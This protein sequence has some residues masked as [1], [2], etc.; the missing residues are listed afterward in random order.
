M[1]NILKKIFNSSRKYLKKAKIL[2]DQI[3]KLDE[4]MTKLKDEDFKKET[5]RLKNIFCQKKNLDELLVEAYALAREASYRITGMKPYYVQLLGAII[6]HQG[7]VAEMK[8]GEGKTLT[9][10]MPSYLNSLSGQSVHIVTVNE[11]LASR[12]AEGIIS[13]VFNFLGLSVGLNTK[14]K[15]NIEK[16]QAY[17]C[18]ILYSTNS[19]LSFDYLRDNMQIDCKNL[20]MQ[21]DYGYAIVD[22]VDSIL[23]D[24]ARTPL[25]ISNQNRQTEFIYREAD[26]FVRTLKNNH[27]II[28]L[29]TKTIEL[30][31][32]GINKAE[33]FFQINNLY[34]V[35]H[36]PL[37]HRIKN[38]LK[39]FFLMH[40]NKDYL[41][42]KDQ[43]LII[44]EFTGRILKGRQF[45][46]G[47][48]QALEAKERVTIKP[49]TTIS[50][51]ITYQNFFRLY[52]KISGMTGTAKTEEDEFRNIYNMEVI[53]IPTNKPMIRIDD[54][55]F[56]FTN[57]NEKWKY[58]I[59]DVKNRHKKGQPVLIGTITVEISEQIS[60]KLH[61]H[62]ITHEVLNAKNHIREA[63]IISKAGIKGS[64][65]IATNMAG[66]GTD[67]ILGKGVIELG[68]LAVIGTEK[69]ESRR[70]DHQLR[71]RAGRQGDPGY[72]RFFISGED[73]LLQ[74]FGGSKLQYIIELLKKI[75]ISENKMTSSKLITRFLI[76]IQK[77]I[78]S[79]N[80]DYR[81]YILKYDDILRIQREIIYKQRKEVLFCDEIKK[82]V[83]NLVE[84]T[85]NYQ[86]SYYFKNSNIN[87]K[88]Q[89]YLEDLIHYLELHF[90]NRNVLYLSEIKHL[91]ENNKNVNIEKIIIDYVQNKAKNILLLP[92]KELIS[93]HQQNFIER[94]RLKILKIIDYHWSLHINNMEY[95][96]KGASFLNYGQQ[97]SLISY[98]KEGRLLFNQMIQQIS[99]DITKI[100]LKIPI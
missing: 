51:T 48:H 100:L 36:A 95:L 27:Y 73:D 23:I 16:K 14:N 88:K 86:I 31:E 13:K 34:N 25:I 80:F 54:P 33:N 59:E 39:A 70:I 9:A 3:N 28:D 32:K 42:V 85:L 93:E 4:K 20:V 46:N 41:V 22:E 65:T 78:E 1:F 30:T 38:A 75:N 24:E 63:E 43:I 71:G 69:H 29:E 76:N 87:I 56:I 94:T 7:N 79:S 61:K 55:D 83:F 97:N 2:A 21:R 90:F 77:K 50:A 66:R 49:E 5:L 67:I 47:L 58:L 6:L 81:K 84:K 44:D 19:E 18:D 89:N 64:V 57:L 40:N 8:T 99:F 68:G 17:D 62:N 98:Q 72:S 45:S 35:N 15:N 11:Y 26:R 52:K 92:P 37:L 91:I 60:K 10:I 12:E 82:L 96:R 53:E 74:R